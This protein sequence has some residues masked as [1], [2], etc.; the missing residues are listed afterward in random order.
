MFDEEEEE[1]V[2]GVVAGWGGT[3]ELS[4]SVVMVPFVSFVRSWRESKAMRGS[5]GSSRQAFCAVEGLKSLSYARQAADAMT[6]VE[7]QWER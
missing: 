6:M 3:A 4:V 2:P 7:C 5:V 1:G